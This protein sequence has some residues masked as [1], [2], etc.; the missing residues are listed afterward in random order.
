MTLRESTSYA[1]NH[2]ENSG[3]RVSSKF[4]RIKIKVPRLYLFRPMC[5]FRAYCKWKLSFQPIAARKI[6]AMNTILQDDARERWALPAKATARLLG[7]SERHLWTLHSSGRIPMPVRLGRS[8]RWR[9]DEL[10]AWL[11][12]GCPSRDRWESKEA[13]Q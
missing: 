9:R 7:I 1:P 13:S 8:V 2:A 4:P 10:L 6:A 3:A 12:A 5:Y 11:Q